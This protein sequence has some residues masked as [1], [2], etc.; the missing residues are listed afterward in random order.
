MKRMRNTVLAVTTIFA[1][2]AYAGPVSDLVGN[3]KL[4]KANEAALAT[5]KADAAAANTN[6]D[7]E[8]RTYLDQ[9]D[10]RLGPIKV[11][12]EADATAL[13]ANVAK[14]EDGVAK[15]NQNCA[16]TLPKPAYERCQ[17][18]KAY[19][20]RRKVELTGEHDRIL[21]RAKDFDKQMGRYTTRM[22]QI[23]TEMKANFARFTQ[24]EDGIAAARTRIRQLTA[25][26]VEA[27]K[28]KS[29]TKTPEEIKYCEDMAWA[30]AQP[31]LPPGP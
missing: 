3:I 1:T 8:R 21:D 6:L 23:A 29:I 24:A 22:D 27:C 10:K 14:Y 25:R 18:E 31:G 20:D 11:A 26:L 15:H 30:G 13:A 7:K 12:I 9:I 2:A 16:G 5:Q 28:D 17:G 19:W 4:T